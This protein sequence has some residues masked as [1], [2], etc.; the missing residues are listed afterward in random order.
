MI[1]L[2]ILFY[3]FIYGIIG[4]LFASL[5]TKFVIKYMNGYIFDFKLKYEDDKH[6]F[7][8]LTWILW[9]IWFIAITMFLVIGYIPYKFIYK[10]IVD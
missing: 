2:T 1:F 9:P 6:V 7:M 5:S 10:N 3:I 4:A 8:V